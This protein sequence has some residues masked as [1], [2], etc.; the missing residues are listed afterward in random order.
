MLAPIGLSLHEEESCAMFGPDKGSCRKLF[1]GMMSCLW[2]LHLSALRPGGHCYCSAACRQRVRRQQR[3]A[4]DQQQQRSRTW[5]ASQPNYRLRKAGTRVTDHDS[6]PIIIST[7]S[8]DAESI[9][10]DYIFRL[11]TGRKSFNTH[12]KMARKVIDFKGRRVIRLRDCHRGSAVRLLT[13][14]RMISTKREIRLCLSDPR[15]QVTP[16]RQLA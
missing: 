11:R 2:E 5:S 15:C 12:R 1:L 9:T 6:R 4:A 14:A 13:T 7:D 10:Y 16:I 3:R 8:S